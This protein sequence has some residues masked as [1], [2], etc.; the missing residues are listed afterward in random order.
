M[1]IPSS[2][3]VR[4]Y[5]RA[6]PTQYTLQYSVDNGKTITNTTSFS[7]SILTQ[8]IQT[9]TGAFFGLYSTGR[10]YPSLVPA[11]FAWARTDEI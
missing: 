7:N 4:L 5:I 6:E 11:D 9:F 10:G 1:T 8:G 2:G 3:A